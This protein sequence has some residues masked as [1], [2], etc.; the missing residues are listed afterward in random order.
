MGSISQPGC[1]SVFYIA[2]FP[3]A[4]GPMYLIGMLCIGTLMVLS[5]P[6]SR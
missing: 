5:V 1:F 6:E 3:R 2:D 4:R